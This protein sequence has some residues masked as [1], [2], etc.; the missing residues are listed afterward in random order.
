MTTL[1]NVTQMRRG[2]LLSGVPLGSSH[3]MSQEF[4]VELNMTQT[5]MSEKFENNQAEVPSFLYTCRNCIN[6]INKLGR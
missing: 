5:D 3:I 6:E 1:C 2:S 4:K